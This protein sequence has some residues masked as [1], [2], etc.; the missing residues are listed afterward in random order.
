MAHKN[1]F[2]KSKT[3]VKAGVRVSS[4][5]PKL[6]QNLSKDRFQKHIRLYKQSEKN[7]S[8]MNQLESYRKYA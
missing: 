8:L 7:E 6:A 2:V 1:Q 4:K 5:S 3:T